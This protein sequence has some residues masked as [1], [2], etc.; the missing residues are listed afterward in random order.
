V[1]FWGF[2][3]V[4]RCFDVFLLLLLF[5]SS[6][7]VFFCLLGQETVLVEIYDPR[8]PSSLCGITSFVL[9]IIYHGLEHHHTYGLFFFLPFLYQEL[10]FFS[11][12]PH[13]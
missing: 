5:S 9:S 12:L 10:G 1:L 13:K 8:T 7:L 4:R 11:L 3:W 2:M 6:F